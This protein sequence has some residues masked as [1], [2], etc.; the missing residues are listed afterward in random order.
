MHYEIDDFTDPWSKPESILFLHGNSESGTA[1]YAWVPHLSRN[2]RLVRPDMRGYGQS[3]PMPRDFPWSLDVL[4]KDYTAL[5]DALGIERF[6][7]VGAKIGGKIARVLAAT[8]PER[9]RTLTV[10]G[11][12]GPSRSESK[13]E[14][15]ALMQSFEKDGI[16]SWA[17]RTMRQRLGSAFPA[18]GAEWWAKFMGRTSLSSQL[19]FIPA[20]AY[21]D[22]RAHIPKIRCPTLA[23]TTSQNPSSS[24]AQTRE[25][26]SSIP[27][28]ELMVLKNDS[29]HP[30]ITNPD[31]SAQ[32][33]RAF[34]MKHQEN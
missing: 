10:V 5:M 28:S 6:H 33:T 22:I 25:W 15:A 23:I 1:W 31:E 21:A 27:G 32:A 16:E 29:F 34:I 7:V 11:S 9:V 20:I 26:Q 4:V 17:R 13:E 24:V 3:T 18:A 2:F 14:I 8:H 12:R 30:A 19:G